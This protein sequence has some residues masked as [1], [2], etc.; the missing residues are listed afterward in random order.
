[1]KDCPFSLSG[2]ETSIKE[3]KY[4][5]S[6]SNSYKNLGSSTPKNV[7]FESF[8]SYFESTEIMYFGSEKYDSIKFCYI[9]EN[10]NDITDS[11]LLG[12]LL[13]DSNV[14]L[15]DYNLIKHL[16]NEKK[17]FFIFFFF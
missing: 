1:M 17:N 12:L 8:K 16:K 3:E 13:R 15:K 2:T 6:K 5:K 11:G 10:K 4:D 7:T 14:H 9:V